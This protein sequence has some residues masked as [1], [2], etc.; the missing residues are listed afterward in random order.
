[1]VW[2]TRKTLAKIYKNY[3]TCMDYQLFNLR[4][5]RLVGYVLLLVLI[6]NTHA[7]DCGNNSGKKRKPTPTDSLNPT[8]DI[9]LTFEELSYNV[10]TRQFAYT[11]QNKGTDPTAGEVSFKYKNTSAIPAQQQATLGGVTEQTMAIP[12]PILPHNTISQTLPLD[13]NGQQ[14][15][16]FTFQLIYLGTLMSEEKRTFDKDAINP[17][18]IYIALKHSDFDQAVALINNAPLVAINYQDPVLKDTPLLLAA[19]AG[20]LDVVTHLLD[21]GAQIHTI[22]AQDRN[23]LMVAAG[24]KANKDLIQL[25]IEHGTDLEQKNTL[26][27]TA[28]QIAADAPDNQAIAQLLAKAEVKKNPQALVNAI[29]EKNYTKVSYML[30]DEIPLEALNYKDSSGKNL[31]GPLC[32][33]ASQGKKDLVK[34]LLKLG[35]KKGIAI[36]N[37]ALS[38]G[39]GYYDITKILFQNGAKDETGDVLQYAIDS[40]REDILQAAFQAGHTLDIHNLAFGSLLVSAA[41]QGQEEIVRFL[42]EQGVRTDL[43]DM[44]HNTAL[45]C[46]QDKPAIK[47]LIE[48]HIAKGNP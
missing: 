2:Q 30:D 21:K 43:Q 5:Y 20:R 17:N 8:I 15:A 7:C 31:S 44:M 6:F 13:F 33:A 42:L 45:D 29:I 24:N 41:Q 3:L 4:K 14:E 19:Q 1:M 12:S 46:A 48:D 38:Y 47:K 32:I 11:I 37:R 40:G 39:K 18:A 23:A 26:R 28:Y 34:R 27:K 36:D 25:L 10:I 22:D 16:T 35:S 9:Q